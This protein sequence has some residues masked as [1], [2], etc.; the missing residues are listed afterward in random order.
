MLIVLQ[1]EMIR[2]NNL[3][4]NAI[5]DEQLAASSSFPFVLQTIGYDSKLSSVTS[6][7]TAT[8]G[9]KLKLTRLVA[10]MVCMLTSLCILI[11][12]VAVTISISPDAANTVKPSSFETVHYPT[13]S[14]IMPQ[15]SLIRFPP[16]TI[17]HRS[18]DLVVPL[19]LHRRQ[20][21]NGIYHR[22]LHRPQVAEAMSEPPKTMDQATV[23]LVEYLDKK[24]GLLAELLNKLRNGEMASIVAH[25]NEVLRLV[26]TPFARRFFNDK[27]THKVGVVFDHLGPDVSGRTHAPNHIGNSKVLIRLNMDLLLPPFRKANQKQAKDE[28]YAALLHQLIHAYFITCCRSPDRSE[29]SDGR[30]RHENHFGII[31]YKIKK[32]S[33]KFGSALPI[34]FAHSIPARSPWHSQRPAIQHQA[35][36][37][38]RMMN[39]DDRRRCP[40]CT[41][42]VDSIPE[43]KLKTWYQN[44]CY[45][46]VKPDI[47]EFNDNGELKSTPAYLIRDKKSDW[48]E[49]HWSRKILKVDRSSI[50]KLTSPFKRKFDNGNRRVEIPKVP[51]HTARALWT[52]LHS[53]SYG[54]SLRNTKNGTK[55]PAL[56][57][58]LDTTMTPYMQN[59]VRIHELAAHL[60]FD[61][62]R[63]RALSRLLEMQ[64]T[65]EDPIPLFERIYNVQDGGFGDA[66][67]E[68]R[69]FAVAFM[70]RYSDILLPGQQAIDW[71]NWS[72]LKEHAGFQY[73]LEN[74]GDA[75]KVDFRIA[76]DDLTKLAIG[77]TK[78]QESIQRAAK[79]PG[80]S[81]LVA[82]NHHHSVQALHAAGPNNVIPPFPSAR[83]AG[84][85]LARPIQHVQHVPVTTPVPYPR[86]TF[87]I[88]RGGQ[89]RDSTR[90][91]GQSN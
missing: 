23:E 30:L 75:L 22:P 88:N 90:R 33:T 84:L 76:G 40:Q 21:R 14:A 50:S 6:N 53:G 8:T 42:T 81:H 66:H 3:N 12:P 17:R 70:K 51:E 73:C 35:L 64:Y 7:H 19:A 13:Y 36:T 43:G 46:N 20:D 1:G 71:S 61:E 27:L 44:K 62:L 80:N 82:A 72:Y 63:R 37:H 89:E 9:S 24:D 85:L 11:K 87:L 10:N 18:R 47:Y 69:Q 32:I 55:G 41:S 78:E 34:D 15:Q 68:L 86:L 67:P 48:V 65:Y 59:E 54:P 83:R 29:E 4:Q 79:F 77:I 2:S 56:I 31:M 60:G 49:I 5:I 25:P 38:S 39:A 74:S 45:Q 91:F 57:K 52:F 58:G 16:N 26:A 28:L